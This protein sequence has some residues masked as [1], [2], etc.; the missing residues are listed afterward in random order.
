MR[1]TVIW[2]PAAQNKL[3]AIW[4]RASDRQAVQ[5]AADTIDR[6]LSQSPETKG[7][8]LNGDQVLIE[9][10]LAVLFTI[11]PDDCQVVVLDVWRW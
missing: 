4:N 11:Q 6:A 2:K 8:A 5:Q 9:K 10:P 7:R 1:Y 3:A